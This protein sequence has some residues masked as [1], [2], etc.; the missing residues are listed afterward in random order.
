LSHG[1]SAGPTALLHEYILGMAPTSPG[2]KTFDVLPSPG[3]LTSAQGRMPTPLGVAEV[4]WHRQ[5]AAW[6][7]E[8][9]VPKGAIARIGVPAADARSLSLDGAAAKT[10]EIQLRRGA[11]LAVPAGEG[12]HEVVTA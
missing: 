6:R 3:D 12:L 10:E 9:S 8:V 11:Y 5:A 7:I 4:R 1:W 2:F